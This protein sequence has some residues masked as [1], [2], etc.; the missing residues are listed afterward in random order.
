MD[1][2]DVAGE[3]IRRRARNARAFS[4]E[5]HAMALELR[6]F[7]AGLRAD[8]MA[9]RESERLRV[10]RRLVWETGAVD[11]GVLSLPSI[12]PFMEVDSRLV[13]RDPVIEKAKTLLCDRYG[14]GRGEAFELLRYR[15]SHSNRKLRDV[16]R[17]LVDRSRG[18][19]G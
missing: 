13:G 10:S 12:G 18:L 6:R 19:E 16:A 8:G 17:A 7:A 3:E 11:D 14:I 15:S 4:A 5:L 2:D 1:A 9:R